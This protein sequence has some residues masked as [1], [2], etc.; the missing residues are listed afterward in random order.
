MTDEEIGRRAVIVA[1]AMEWIGTPYRHQASAIGQ[2]ADC[3]GLVRGVWRHLYGEEPEAPPPYT[4]DWTER[5]GEPLRGAAERWLE[6]KDARRLLPGDVLLFRMVRDGPAKHC[7]V[8]L[9]E[10]RF[11]HA[12]SGRAVTA[13]WLSRWWRERIVA[14]YAFPQLSE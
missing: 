8:H 11:V 9:G 7:G 4:P 10:D 2:G 5:G 3:L 14:A 12:Y 13:S 1:H 6:P